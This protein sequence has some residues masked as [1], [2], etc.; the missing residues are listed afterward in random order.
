MFSDDGLASV[1]EIRFILLFCG[2]PDHR[3]VSAVH[4]TIFSCAPMGR[5]FSS[6]DTLMLCNRRLYVILLVGQ[7]DCSTVL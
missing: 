3:S 4:G 1:T 6:I 2:D 7:E 5:E